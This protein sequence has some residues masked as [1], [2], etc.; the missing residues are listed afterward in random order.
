M[1]IARP[2]LNT[3]RVNKD[4]GFTLVELMIAV[5]I[6]GIVSIA[7]Y[8]AYV[9]QQRSA[10]AQEQVGEMQQ[11]IRAGLNIMEHEIRM[12][13]HDPRASAGAS[14]TTANASQLIFTMVADTDGN[15]ND[16]DGTKDEE[17]E[18]ESVEYYLYD[19]YSDGDQDLGR[20][21]PTNTQAVAENIDAI[22]FRYT[23][24]DAS[25]TLTPTAAQLADIRAVQVSILA[26]AGRADQNFTNTMTYTPA[27]GNAW[28]LNG[29]AAGSAPND[30]FRRRL[31]I[32]T[33]KCRNMGL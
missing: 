18:L 1:K 17:D 5:A 4:N 9:A 19:A 7:I 6:S 12:A 30:N 23:L 33:I 16:G 20:R 25:Q 22:E 2:P 11:S 14:I 3:R 28:D 13:G 27:S 26:R 8:S 10:I 29:A 15:D 21:T 24:N 31:F 32:T